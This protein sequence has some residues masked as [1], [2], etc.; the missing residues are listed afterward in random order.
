MKAKLYLAIIAAFGI[1]ACMS[2]CGKPHTGQ[3]KM[4]VAASIA[5]L[6]Y[7]SQQVGGDRVKVTLLVPPGSNPHTYQIQP[8]QMT[9]LSKASVLVLN[10]VGLEFWA[11][12]VVDAANNPKLIVTDTADGLQIIDEEAGHGHEHGNPHVWLDPAD[13]IHQVEKIRDAFVKADPSHAEQYRANAN[14]LIERLKELDADIR[15]EVSGFGHKSFVTFHPTWTY[16]AH[17]YGLNQAAEIE[18]SPGK[19]P[20]PRDISQAIKIARKLKVRA[21]FAEP[22]MSPK[23]AHVV[24][25]EADAKVL[26]LDAFGQPPSY[27]YFTN[28]RDNLSKM[29]GALK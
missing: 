28:M 8:N 7:F 4:M 21:I 25:E 3:D 29:A 12:R 6:Y 17:R 16:F 15:A 14:R 13:A 23:A 1:L 10:G 20:S 27:D 18:P 5:P 24:A 11:D 19:E 9:D 2:G 22:Q 26:L